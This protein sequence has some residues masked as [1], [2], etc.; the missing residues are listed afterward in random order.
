MATVGLALP[1]IRT[2]GGYFVS[3][4][5]YDAAWGN[6][7]LALQCPTGG[8]PMQR[9]FGSNLAK[10]LFDPVDDASRQLVVRSIVQAAA[11]WVPSITINTVD[12]QSTK[13]TVSVKVTFS[14]VKDAHALTAR[15]FTVSKLGA[16][17]TLQGS[18][19]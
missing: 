17:L 12:V 2:A 14:L 13:G 1:A 11:Q 18:R 7:I 3:K 8:R 4:N 15:T 19:T 9:T 6:L 16:I 5:E 10:I